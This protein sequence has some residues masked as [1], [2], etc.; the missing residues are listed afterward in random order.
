MLTCAIYS[1]KKENNSISAGSSYRRTVTNGS[2]I[3]VFANTGEIKNQSILNRFTQTDDQMISNV[4]D[5]LRG[6]DSIRILDGSSANLFEYSTYNLYTYSKTS[7][8]Y[9]FS[10]KDTFTGYS[11]GDLF[12]RSLNYTM[13]LYKPIVYSETIVSSTAGFY[14]F[15]YKGRRQY[16]IQKDKDRLIMP[17]IVYNDH[18]SAASITYTLQNKLDQQ[19]YKTLQPKDTIVLK[20]YSIAYE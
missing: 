7:K 14:Q 16:F 1:C 18:N 15:Q 6:L 19:F 3:R 10:S 12:T 9:N 5:H 11:Y 2:S 8:D 17:W 4:G 13:S 20:E